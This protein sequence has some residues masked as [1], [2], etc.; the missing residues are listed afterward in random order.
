MDFRHDT[1]LTLC[2]IGN[3]TKT[4]KHL[5]ITQPAVTQHIQY[6][7]EYYNCKLFVHNNKKIKLTRQGEYL[8]DF[9]KTVSA[10][11][12]RFKK[13]L[14]EMH[15]EEIT[16]QFGATLSIGEYV[17][18]EIIS[19]LLQKNPKLKIHMHVANTQTLLE[20]LN[21]GQLDF[22]VVEGFFNKADYHSK[23]LSTE[24]FIPICSVN[25]PL[26]EGTK[27]L[28]EITKERLIL[29]ESGSGTR[30]ILENILKKYNYTVDNFQNTIEI[31]N[32][33]A[34]K[35]LVADNLGISFLYEVV[36]KREIEEGIIK[37]INISDF[38]IVREFNFV[39]LKDSFFKEEYMSYF[40]IMKEFIKTEDRI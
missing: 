21:L 4:A 20:K 29:R 36:V 31:E 19:E 38:N 37:K 9:I 28:E 11:R 7:E 3:Y 35:K 13:N 17:M 12:Q 16:V 33:N 39:F 26:A 40:N 2:E 23:T 15:L 32:M 25:S 6:L 10:D 14:S 18:P 5:H 27:S 8:K 30:N 22:I 1:F 34:I 24:K